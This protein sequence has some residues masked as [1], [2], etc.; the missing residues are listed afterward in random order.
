MEEKI[1]AKEGRGYSKVWND[2]DVQIIQWFDNRSVLVDSNFQD[3]TPEKNVR[4]FDKKFKVI[5]SNVPQPS[6]IAEYNK[7]MGVDL[8]DNA[9]ANLRPTIKSKK[10]YFC[11]ALNCIRTLLSGELGKDYTLVSFVSKR[12]HRSSRSC[13]S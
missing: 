10:W 7:N 12:C 9:L 13:S 6:A 2:G 3:V 1:I 5:R 8:L 4:R 11:I